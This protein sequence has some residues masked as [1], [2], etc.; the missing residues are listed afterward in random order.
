MRTPEEYLNKNKQIIPCDGKKPIKDGWQ[1]K[2]FNL[3]DFKPDNNIGLKLNEDSDIDIETNLCLPFVEKYISPCSAVFGRGEKPRSH[4]LFKGV[5]KAKKFILHDD[6]KGYFNDLP[7]G[8]CLIECRHGN[9][10]SGLE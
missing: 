4:F 1:K 7:H 9:V 2:T 6:L 10:I 5:S 3:E 8:A